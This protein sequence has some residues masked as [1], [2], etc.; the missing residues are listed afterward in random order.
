MNPFEAKYT[1]E[2]LELLAELE[3]GMLLLETH[4]DDAS[5]IQQV[6]RN[7][8][9]LK[10]NSAMMGFRTIT[11]FT[12]H[13]EAIYELVRAGK[14]KVSA[15]IIN[16]T[17]ASLDHLSGLLN[18]D[19]QIGD[20]NRHIHDI[21]TNDIVTIIS[22]SNEESRES[23]PVAFEGQT[24]NK[25]E[26]LTIVTDDTAIYK[27]KTA[28]PGIRVPV[29][30][31]DTMMSLV[32]ELITLQAKLNVLTSEHPQ[33]DLVAAAESLE[34]ISTRIR[35][36]AFSMCMVPVENMVTPFH[37]MVRDLAAEL[38]KEID[39]VTEGTETELDKN[40]ME[41]LQ[42]PLMHLLRNSIDHGIEEPELRQQ[43][44][45]PRHGR[46]VLKAYCAGAYVYL[47]IQD[48]GKGMN[49]EKIRKTAVR[50]GL[51]AESDVISDKELQQ[52][53]FVP[54]FSTADQI[55]ETS[56]RGVGMDVVKR[57]IA[58]IKGQVSIY[59]TEHEGTTV[60]IQLP[61]TLS[62][63]DGLLVK[64]NGADYVIPLSAV[65]ICHEVSSVQLM[66]GFAQVMVIDEQ[67]I[68]F[69]NLQQELEGFD[70]GPQSHEIV[71]VHYGEKKIGLLV[72]L[73]AGKFQAVLKPLGR[74][75]NHLD[76]VSGATILGDGNI[77]L[78]LDTNKVI[79]Q[80]LN[81]KSK[82]I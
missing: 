76:I 16:I 65:D 29:E 44:G 78:V 50:N 27:R 75:F 79:A 9:T 74:Y 26:P 82:A 66:N 60:I 49:I 22:Y 68:P 23:E 41:G 81:K 52:L 35:D 48:D 7:L 37:R 45:K 40:I 72:D 57:R 63:I 36:N 18:G 58:D 31:L 42:D 24:V 54:G 39:F 15:V 46:I 59:S 70:A 17:L 73:I 62:I 21:L 64:V 80:S 13:L 69:I 51:I 11:D 2:A 30:R 61:I 6:F 14:L 4:P 32:T 5:L 1:S 12:H 43:K 3:K 67:A 34:K 77:A 56:G 47:E 19:K 38:H 55:T 10:G 8:H 53:V 71:I 28:I 33:P 20:N 25:G